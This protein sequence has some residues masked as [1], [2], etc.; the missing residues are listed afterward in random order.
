VLAVNAGSDSISVFRIRQDEL[1]L[2]DTE[3][4]GGLLPTSLAVSNGLVVVL[5]AG[6][7]NTIAG[8]QLSPAGHLTPIP[9]FTRPLSAAQTGPGQVGFSHDGGTIIVSERATSRLST[10]TFD[11]EFL[12]GPF[13][14]PSAGPTPFG[15][16]SGQRNTLLVSE[17]GAG[18]GASTYRVDGRDLNA[19]SAAVMTGQRAA[20]WAVVTPNGRFGYVT[21][22]GTGN[23]S[24]FS[25]APDGSAA[26]LDVDG[27]TAI[28]GGNPTDMA[29]SLNGRYLY[30]RVAN[31]ASIAVFR[32]EADGSLAPLPWLT[33]TPAGV[34]GLAGF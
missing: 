30:A 29:M 1:Q 4:S 3:P 20:C 12:D 16:A 18:G 33:G 5:N 14:T 2:T 11:G 22:A 15:F 7:P 21:N 31:L 27:A 24:G 34:A 19:V 9:G 8:F 17:A 26:L 23:I 6:A 32:I 25:I 10:F 13:V 28:T